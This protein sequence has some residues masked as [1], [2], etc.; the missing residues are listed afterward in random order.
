M[1]VFVGNFVWWEGGGGRLLTRAPFPY[2]SLL[3]L[4][5]IEM[6]TDGI[7]MRMLRCDLRRKSYNS[8]RPC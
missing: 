4:S 7:V 1:R 8:N 2:T 6:I 5:C 3:P